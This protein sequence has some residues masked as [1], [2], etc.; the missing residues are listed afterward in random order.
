[1]Y[2]RFEETK[3]SKV[4]IGYQS[5]LLPINRCVRRIQDGTNKN[6]KINNCDRF[7]VSQ[8][9]RLVEI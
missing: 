5:V 9:D 1:M 2:L 6:V 3:K 4:N 7:A 8:L